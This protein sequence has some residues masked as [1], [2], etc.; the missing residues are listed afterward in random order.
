[1]TTPN[2]MR[3]LDARI[4]LTYDGAFYVLIDT[5]TAS[6]IYLDPDTWRAMIEAKAR[7]DDMRKQRIL[8]GEEEG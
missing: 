8:D 7:I 6:R 5:G 3:G 2:Y 4:Y 1:M